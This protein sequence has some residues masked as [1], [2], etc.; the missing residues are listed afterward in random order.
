ML[1]VPTQGL[2]RRQGNVLASNN[3]VLARDES[4]R[5]S[6]FGNCADIVSPTVSILKPSTSPR[7]GQA[8]ASS[9]LVP[10]V[11]PCPNKFRRHHPHPFAVSTSMFPISASAQI[12]SSAKISE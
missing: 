5:P 9:F 4:S 8:P 6:I 2:E 3:K 1:H 10:F 12:A 11:L 7:V